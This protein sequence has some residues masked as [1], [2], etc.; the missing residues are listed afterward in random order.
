MEFSRF[1]NINNGVTIVII[2]TTIAIALTSTTYAALSVSQ[3]VH[4]TGSV[5]VSPNLGVYS[6]IYCQHHASTINWGNITPGSNITRV[7]YI[8]NTGGG[9]SLSLS[10]STS[11]WNPAS[12]NGPMIISWDQEGTKLAPGQSVAATL[13]LSTSSSIDDVTNFNVQITIKGTQSTMAS[14]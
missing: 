11:N 1:K 14:K 13:K 4:S 6:D 10:M 9:V 5:N 12:A 7:V 3:N 2:L 8:K